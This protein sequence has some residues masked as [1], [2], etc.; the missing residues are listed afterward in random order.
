MQPAKILLALVSPT[1]HFLLSSTEQMNLSEYTISTVASID[2]E[3]FLV[4]ITDAYI[5]V[6]LNRVG[7]PSIR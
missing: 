5:P 7:I 1:F 2:I 6:D 4:Q 3:W